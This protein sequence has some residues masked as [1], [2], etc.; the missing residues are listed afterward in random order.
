MKKTAG[1]DYVRMASFIFTNDFE[2]ANSSKASGVLFNKFMILLNRELLSE[3]IDIKLP[4]CWYRWGDEVV[5]YG[6]N[7]LEW[8][9]D[10]PHFT[11]VE[12]RGSV[13]KDYNSNDQ[14]INIIE[15]YSKEFIRKYSGSECVELAIDEVYSEAPFKFQND[16]RKLRESL[17]ISRTNVGYDNFKSYV[18]NLFDI[19]MESFPNDFSNINKQKSEFES[20]FRMAVKNSSRDDLF[21]LTECFWFFFCYHLRIN[22]K[23]HSNINKTTLEIWKE[24]IPLENSRFEHDI[25]TFAYHLCP[26]DCGDPEILRLIK[27]REDSIS[28]SESILNYICGDN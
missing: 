15:K 23:C 11:S 17:K 16:Y 9:H 18:I 3:N 27:E 7:Y 21:D 25:R 5:R 28:E 8:N 12:Y 20:V 24:V 19:A 26:N 22:R 1:V 10:D 2:K 14:I 4:H 6:L 13:P